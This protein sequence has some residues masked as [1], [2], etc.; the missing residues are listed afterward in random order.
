MSSGIGR[1]MAHGSTGSPIS[2]RPRR[3]PRRSST[4]PLS[5]RVRLPHECTN[6]MWTDLDSYLRSRLHARQTTMS[7][8]Q[9]CFASSAPRSPASALMRSQGLPVLWAYEL[10]EAETP[11][12][13]R[14]PAR[15]G[16][17][18]PR[19]L[20]APRGTRHATRGSHPATPPRRIHASV[21]VA[22]PGRCSLRAVRYSRRPRHPA[23]RC[24]PTP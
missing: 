23:A 5:N 15:A 6:V 22:P 10:G 2:M 12:R 4:S 20:L 21:T 16:R 14:R 13:P 3:S 9:P 1:P 17:P 18:R 11:R 7:R 8:R 24:W 19:G